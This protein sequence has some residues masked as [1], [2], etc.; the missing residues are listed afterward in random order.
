MVTIVFGKL[1]A[2]FDR[3]LMKFLANGFMLLKVDQKLMKRSKMIVTVM[4]KKKIR[5]AEKGISANKLAIAIAEG[6]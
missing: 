4:L 1:E 2:T 5:R 3:F 6:R